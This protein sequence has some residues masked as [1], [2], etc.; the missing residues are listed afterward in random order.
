MLQSRRR[1]LAGVSGIGAAALLRAP[2]LAAEGPPETTSVRLP[3][4]Q[5]ICVAPQDVV[6]DLLRAE[7]FTDIRYVPVSPGRNV[8]DAIAHGEIDFGLNYAPLQVA[9]IDHSVAMKVLAGIHVGCFEL[10]VTDAI[11]GL[12]DLVGK[13][14][15]IPATGTPEHLFLS[16]I[17]GDVGINP[18]TIDWVTSGPKIRPKQ[19]FV[20]GKIDAFLG[21]PP[22]PQEL[23]A[24][25]IGRVILNSAVDRPWSQ[26]F[27][28]MLA[29]SAHYVEKQPIATMR[30]VRAILKATDLCAADPPRAARLLVDGG[31]TSR[32]DYALQT[33]QE[34]PYDKWR[35][36]D[37]EDTIRFYSLR[38]HELGM[39]KSTPQQ[40]I[41]D[42]TDWRFLN[43]LKKELKA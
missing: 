13:K 37:A 23:R 36:Y 5:S 12:P 30:V 28:C 11:H 24:K 26:Y 16:V 40:I 41:T 39:I 22:E 1:F 8:P 4:T 31:F 3:K 7:G 20:D 17:A 25:R 14:V 9:G 35:E 18:T 15:G 10:F 42:G 2:A 32:Y 27:C 33:L 34:L 43:E 29:S 6:A 19:L 38:L 21:F